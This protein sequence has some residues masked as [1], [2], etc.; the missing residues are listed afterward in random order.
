MRTQSSIIHQ[1]APHECESIR[2][3]PLVFEVDFARDPVQGRFAEA[4]GA[5][6]ERR[7]RDQLHAAD[8]GADGDE[9]WMRTGFQQCVERLE[10]D[11]GP[12]HVYL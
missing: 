10:E 2:T 7:E 11:D 3:E 12:D 4:V 8:G 1:Q 5:D 9:A 6:V